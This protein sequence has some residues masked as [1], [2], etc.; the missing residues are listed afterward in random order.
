MSNYNQPEI[1]SIAHTPEQL[2]EQTLRYYGK[3]AA[4]AA[5]IALDAYKVWAAKKA[6]DY[7]NTF[8]VDNWI[9]GYFLEINHYDN[10]IPCQNMEAARNNFLPRWCSNAAG[11]AR[12]QRHRPQLGIKYGS[13]DLR[14]SVFVKLDLLNV[15]FTGYGTEFVNAVSSACY[16]RALQHRDLDPWLRQSIV[17]P[18]LPALAVPAQVAVPA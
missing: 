1:D 15:S 6:R 16:Q 4:L 9:V 11:G 2:W 13:D 17:Y 12:F 3:P 7:H 5:V 18:S 14:L 8:N 10:P